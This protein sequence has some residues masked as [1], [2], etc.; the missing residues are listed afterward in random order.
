MAR[1]VGVEGRRGEMAAIGIPARS[2]IQL[3]EGLTTD[4][5]WVQASIMLTNGNAAQ[6]E[7][8]KSKGRGSVTTYELLR[9]A[10]GKRTVI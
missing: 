4:I 1:E 9:T 7:S 8:A 5:T 2:V 6:P 3:L 10:S